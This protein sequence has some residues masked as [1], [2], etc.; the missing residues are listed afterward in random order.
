MD[1]QIVKGRPTRGHYSLRS[2]AKV[3]GRR[4]T[5][6]Y[7]HPKGTSDFWKD[8][9]VRNRIFREINA[10]V[11]YLGVR[12]WFC[13][14]NRVTRRLYYMLTLILGFLESLVLSAQ[15]YIFY[16]GILKLI[17]DRTMTY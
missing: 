15:R 8:V 16:S 5:D 9:L 17:V 13:A 1:T 3:S 2:P 10:A 12:L 4:K 7:L 11:N 6:I 14:M